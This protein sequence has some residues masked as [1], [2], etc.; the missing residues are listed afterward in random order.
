MSTIDALYKIRQEAT[1]RRITQRDEAWPLFVRRIELSTETAEL[2]T[3]GRT[4][5]RLY[6]KQDFYSIE[7]SGETVSICIQTLGDGFVEFKFGLADGKLISID[8]WG[9]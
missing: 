2:T 6:T 8:G 9:E 3:I 7:F 5:L 1:A 4:L